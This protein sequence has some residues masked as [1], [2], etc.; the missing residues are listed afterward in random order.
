MIP[1][2]GQIKQKLCAVVVH[3]KMLLPQSWIKG[4]HTFQCY[5]CKNQGNI[6]VTPEWPWMR[7]KLKKKTKKTKKQWGWIEWW[8]STDE[9]WA[10]VVCWSLM[11][12]VPSDGFPGPGLCR[13]REA[14]RVMILPN[15]TSLP[16]ILM[17]T[18]PSI[19]MRCWFSQCWAN[20]KAVLWQ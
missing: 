20:H 3:E 17:P 11:V 10:Y 6:P 4:S 8:V 2:L 7:W 1:I 19:L 18:F 9:S 14:F 16:Y 5:L 13:V 12:D 15:E